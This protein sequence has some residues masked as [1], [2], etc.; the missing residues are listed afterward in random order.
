MQHVETLITAQDGYPAFERRVLAAHQSVVMGFRVFDPLTPLLSPEAQRIGD[1]WVDLLVD[2]LN[3]GVDITLHLSDFDPLVATDLHRKTWHSVRILRAISELARPDAAKLTVHPLLHPARIGQLAA[4][5]TAPMVIARKQR[6]RNRFTQNTDPKRLNALFEL[7][8]VR[9]ALSHTDPTQPGSFPASH[10]QKVAVIDN[11]WTYIGGLDLDERRLD[12][13]DHD[14]HADE[15]WHDVQLL[16][17]DPDLAQSA[18]A[19][20]DSFAAVTGGARP[21]DPSAPPLL[22]T[23]SAARLK[24]QFWTFSPQTIVSEIHAAHMRRIATATQLIYLE[25]QFFRDTGIAR[26]LARRARANPDLHL[27]L[28]LPG[29]PNTVAFRDKP[30]LDGRVGDYLQAKCLRILRKPFG[31]RLLLASPVQPRAPRPTEEKIDRATLHKAPLVYVHAKVSVFDNTSAI[32]SSA[33]LN[34]RS[35][36]WD[37][38]LG[39]ELTQGATVQDIRQKCL[40]HWLGPEADALPTALDELFDLLRD[41]LTRNAATAP[42]RRD[43]FLVPYDLSAAEKTALAVPGVPD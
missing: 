20:L 10:H 3:R 6:L 13:K 43:G 42:S 19:H 39:V 36:K 9:H 27:I 15:T 40:L 24:G 18:R 41:T 8:G 1:T 29:A 22:R 35:M 34:G 11:R 31:N 12:T 28:I 37:T 7:P 17:D 5:L 26:A 33:N 38:E 4:L 14:C 2:A 23:M 25:T 32:V 16:I 30:G 21:A